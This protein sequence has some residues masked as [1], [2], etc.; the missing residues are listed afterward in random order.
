MNAP[1]VSARLGTTRRR[2]STGASRLKLQND[3]LMDKL[4]RIMQAMSGATQELT[5]LKRQL[6]RLEAENSTLR[7]ELRRLRGRLGPAAS[8]G[9]G[10]APESAEPSSQSQR[11]PYPPLTAR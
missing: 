6:R 9:R 7:S 11:V 4:G 8:P 2:P 10:P 5:T 3:A 1:P